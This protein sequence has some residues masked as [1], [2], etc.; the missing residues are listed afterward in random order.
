[1]AIGVVM[2]EVN[3]A[4]LKSGPKTVVDRL[5]KLAALARYAAVETEDTDAGFEFDTPKGEAENANE[6]NCECEHDDEDR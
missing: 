2:G 3:A 5:K 6:E 1:V 4:L